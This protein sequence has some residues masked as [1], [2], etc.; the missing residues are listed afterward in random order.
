MSQRTYRR[1]QTLILAIMGLFTLSLTWE[2][3][4]MSYLGAAMIPLELLSGFGLLALALAALAA[5]EQGKGTL[6]R[7]AGWGLVLLALPILLA[8][9][10]LQRPLGAAALG[11]R[12]LNP[13]AVAGAGSGLPAPGSLSAEERNVKDWAEALTEAPLPADLSGL[14]ASVNGF[15][16]H[17]AR[18]GQ[19]RFWLARYTVVGGLGGALAYA[20]V[21]DWQAAEDFP[22]DEWV[23]VD[24]T[25][26]VLELD[27]RTFPLIHAQRVVPVQAPTVPYLAP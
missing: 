1:L 10:T 19:G 13:R 21:V 4:L 15:V 22:N 11:G 5:R 2:G 7:Q 26:D 8:A 14:P 17:D 9:L 6:P 27:R 20:A 23:R 12:L 3:T 16:A 18:L 25:V 24:G